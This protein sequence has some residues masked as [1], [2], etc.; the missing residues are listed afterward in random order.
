M[1]LNTSTSLGIILTIKKTISIKKAKAVFI[2]FTSRFGRSKTNYHYKTKEQMAR[3]L[4][5]WARDLN[6]LDDNQIERGHGNLRKSGKTWPPCL[7]EFLLMCKTHGGGVVV[8]QE[9]KVNVK[10]TPALISAE[11]LKARKIL[12][13]RLVVSDGEAC[14]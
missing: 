12:K 4:R 5:E 14:P 11:L 6:E 2:R 7:Q 10:Q 3:A 9:A 1:Q 8:E 13:P